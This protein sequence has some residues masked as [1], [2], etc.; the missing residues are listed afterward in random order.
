MYITGREIKNDYQLLRE[1]RTKE[2]MHQ[3]QCSSYHMLLEVMKSNYIINVSQ[4]PFH[5]GFMGILLWCIQFL[6]EAELYEYRFLSI[7]WSLLYRQPFK[8]IYHDDAC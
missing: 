3:R 2:L 7:I 4:K 5:T 6:L 1:G 8:H